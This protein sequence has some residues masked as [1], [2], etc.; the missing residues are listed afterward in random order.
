VPR[1]GSLPHTVGDT[2][3]YTKD[4]RVA[5]QFGQNLAR[6]RHRAGLSQVELAKLAG[7][8]WSA[9][10]HFERGRREPRYAVLLRLAGALDVSIAELVEGIQWEP[11]Q[12]R[13]DKGTF[14]IG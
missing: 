6:L 14:R 8:H 1:S 5:N 11:P 12:S 13:D 4:R 2:L 10:S 7:I 3:A 9:I